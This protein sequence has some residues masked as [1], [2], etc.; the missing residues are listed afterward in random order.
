VNNEQQDTTPRE[1]GWP[2]TSI[3]IFG[4]FGSDTPEGRRV[5]WRT[6]G[7]LVVFVAAALGLRGLLMPQVPPLVWGLMV[8]LSVAS[9]FSAHADY[10]R[11]LDELARALQLAAF[12]FAYGCVF[13]I[14]AAL[15]GFSAAGVITVDPVVWFAALVV[16][17]PL[18]AAALARLARRY[19]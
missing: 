15:Y 19:E 8:P 9:I 18:R 4:F 13:V 14:A 6:T 5:A 7:A 1:P 3:L 11:S 17:E 10:V 16:A 2:Y 12:A